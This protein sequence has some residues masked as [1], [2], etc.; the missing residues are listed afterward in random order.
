M[1]DS[2]DWLEAHENA[3]PITGREL[4]RRAGF[5]APP[6]EAVDDVQLRGRLWELTYALAARRIFLHNTNHLSDRDLY[7]WLHDDWLA[8][9]TLDIPFEAE[10]NCNVDILGRC[11]DEDTAIFLR[12]YSGDEERARWAA[13]FPAD[14]LPPREKPP[15][16]RDRFLPASPEP[17]QPPEASGLPDW[18]DLDDE[19][20][21]PPFDTPETDDPLGLSEVDREIRA[22]HRRS[23]SGET[24]PPT[25]RPAEPPRNEREVFE[26]IAKIDRDGWQRPH[27]E[28]ARTGVV[29]LPPDEITDETISPKLWELLHEL[30]CR[31]FY[32]LNSDHLSDREVYTHLW[33]EDLRE[34]AML[35]GR[36]KHGGWFHDFV[37]SGGDEDTQTW[38]RYYA[39]DEA[40]ADHARENPKAPMPPR[41]KAP[42]NRDWRLPKGPF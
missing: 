38:L 3:P 32:V 34:P 29:L 5:E 37:G 11:T 30:A 23:A 12:Y 35:P 27:E 4:L 1:P 21:E 28:L 6:P 16:D 10:W 31:G 17:P 40:R 18:A 14:K 7:V 8:G 25:P 33:R 26:R 15:F 42:F 13:D 41:E 20:G 24:A 2:P 22:G 19:L 36:S 9:E 39:S